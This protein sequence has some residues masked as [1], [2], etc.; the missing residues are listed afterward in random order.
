MEPATNDRKLTTLEEA[1][2]SVFTE[3]LSTAVRSYI[4]AESGVTLEKHAQVL[5]QKSMRQ[6][7]LK[8]VLADLILSSEIESL[9]LEEEATF[10]LGRLP[11]LHRDPFDR[12]L[13]CQAIVGG[14]AMLTPDETIMK[15]PVRFL[16]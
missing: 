10:Y 14:L 2:P 8:S 1:S 3:V 9:P 13:I 15:Y 7:L 11:D 12:M 16:W 5:R 6:G 4:S